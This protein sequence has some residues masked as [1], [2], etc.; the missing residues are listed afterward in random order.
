VK[1]PV[2]FGAS[3]GIPKDPDNSAL[4]MAVD[5]LG[6]DPMAVVGTVQQAV[7]DGVIAYVR[8]RV[9]GGGGGAVGMVHRGEWSA[10]VQY[11][12]QNVVT[13]GTLGEFVA[14][15]TPAIGVPPESGAPNWH[16]LMWPSPGV[17]A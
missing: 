1:G 11:G 14:L 2:A 4:G 3:V 8:V 10:A 12:S 17:W 9:T 15:A 13:R 6:G 7:A 5:Y 16:G